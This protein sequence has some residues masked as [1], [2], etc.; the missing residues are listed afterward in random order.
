[1]EAIE[2]L[3]HDA[4]G[5]ID[6]D[7]IGLIDDLEGKEVFDLYCGTGTISQVMALRAKHVLGV[8]IV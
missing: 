8:E 6:D 5:L 3:Y 4:I 1:M 7:A 2:R